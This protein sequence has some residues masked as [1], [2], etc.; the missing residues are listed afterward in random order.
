M[1]CVG[2]YF[3]YNCLAHERAIGV[4]DALVDVPA[5]TSTSFALY[6]FLG[7]MVALVRRVQFVC[8]LPGIP[9]QLPLAD[10][11]VSP[12][13]ARVMATITANEAATAMRRVENESLGRKKRSCLLLP[14]VN[15]V[16]VSMA[17]VAVKYPRVRVTPSF[18]FLSSP[19]CVFL[20]VSPR[21]TSV[22]PDWQAKELLQ[23]LSDF[24]DDTADDPYCLFGMAG[25]DLPDTW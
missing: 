11:S 16:N 6:W 12:S 4:L 18:C 19:R 21:T 17:T 23:P 8:W 2:S 22:V 24:G 13:S 9:E 1:V 15:E 14:P 25:H 7:G 20:S 3:T 5:R 10:R